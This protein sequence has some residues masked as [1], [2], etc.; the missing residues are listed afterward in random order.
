VA[1]VLFVVAIIIIIALIKWRMAVNLRKAGEAGG[2]R[3]ILN[4]DSTDH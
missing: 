1:V 2:A 4:E 3:K